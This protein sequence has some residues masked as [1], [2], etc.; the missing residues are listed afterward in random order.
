MLEETLLVYAFAGIDAALAGVMKRL[1]R[2]EKIVFEPK[3]EFRES[4][5]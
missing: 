2:A 1:R 4:R 5:R 3:S